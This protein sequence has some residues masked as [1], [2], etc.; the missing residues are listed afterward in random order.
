MAW[1]YAAFK[2]LIV[3]VGVETIKPDLH[4][5]AF[6]EATVG[7]RLSDSEAVMILERAARDLG[8]RALQLDAQIWTY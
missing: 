8:I 2:W 3:R 1:A 4:V 7:F 6:V 5:L